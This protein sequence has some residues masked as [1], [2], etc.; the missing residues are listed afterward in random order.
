MDQPTGIRPRK[1]P[2]YEARRAIVL[3]LFRLAGW[4]VEGTAPAE[5]KFVVI[6]A[7]HTSNWDL[8]LML[9]V[10]F[11]FRIKLRW[12]GKDTLFKPPFGGF[13]KALGGIPIDRSKAN[14]VVSQMVEIYRDADSLAVAIPPEGTRADVTVWK[15]G[16]YNIAH[17][18]GVPIALGFLDYGRKVGGIGGVFRTTGDY[19]TDL[20]EIQAFYAPIKGKHQRPPAKLPTEE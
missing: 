11:K 16:F 15:T 2:F 8:P 20:K 14:N 13:M 10:A 9:A 12:M 6:A 19:E 1:N 4:R 18:A 7:P 3:G 5:D 17:A